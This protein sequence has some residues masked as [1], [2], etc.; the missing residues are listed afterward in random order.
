VFLLMSEYRL[1]PEGAL[2]YTPHGDL[3][4]FWKLPVRSS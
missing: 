4:G 1:D 2:E 3:R